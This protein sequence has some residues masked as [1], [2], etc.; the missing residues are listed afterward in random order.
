L[1]KVRALRLSIR[2]LLVFTIVILVVSL[3]TL[4]SFISSISSETFN[5]SLTKNEAT[6]DLMFKFNANPRNNGLLGISLLFE[7]TI[8]DPD[9]RI[10]AT[11]STYVY[12]E[13]DGSQSF[14]ITL[15][16]PAEFVPGGEL[17]NAKGYFQMKMNVRTL[18]DL[19]GFTQI[20][21]IGSGGT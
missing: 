19:V 16:V 5:L 18:G 1:K 2:V 21:K 6:G 14:S 15:T 3:Y 13:A 4:F 11:N 8:L 10:I 20:I 9:Y 17:Q 12:I 7:L